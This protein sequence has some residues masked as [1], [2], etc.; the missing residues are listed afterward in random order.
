MLDTSEG[1]TPKL[2]TPKEVAAHF[3]ITVGALRNRR[4]RGQIEGMRVSENYFMYT[5]E[6]VDKANIAVIRRRGPKPKEIKTDEKP[7]K[8]AA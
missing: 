7:Q 3:G 1:D 6:Q 8:K 5:Q 4:N 2:Y